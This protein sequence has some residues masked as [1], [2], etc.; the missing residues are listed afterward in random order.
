M[1]VFLS[2]CIAIILIKLNTGFAYR[3]TILH[4]NDLHA[5]FEETNAY[6]GLCF[7][8]DRKAGKCYGGVARR[9]AAI[10]QI[11]G[12]EPNVILLDAGDVLTGTLWYNVYRG[13]ASWKFMNELRYDVMTLGNHDFDD[14]PAITA[15]FLRNVN[16][17]VVIPTLTQVRN[18]YGPGKIHFSLKARVSSPGPGPNIRFLPEIQSVRTATDELRQKGINKIIAL[19]HS[20]IWVDEEIA[21]QVSG[22]DVVV[23]GHSNTFLY[24]GTPIKELTPKGPYPMVVKS[25]EGNKVPVVQAYAYGVYL[26]RL[27][28]EFDSQGKVTKWSGQPILLDNSVAKDTSAQRQVTVMKGEVDK[29]SQ[30]K[31]GRSLVYLNA[32]QVHCRLNECNLG[33]LVTDAMVFHYA[34]QTAQSV[35]WTKASIALQSSG[36]IMASIGVSPEEFITYGHM[37]NSLPYG[38][39]IDLVE[40]RG[41]DLKNVLEHSVSAYDTKNPRGSFL[42]V[43]GLRV[44][45]NINKPSG[46]RVT[47]V[48]TLCTQCREPIYQPLNNTAVYNVILPSY[49][50]NGG[51]GYT[52]IKDKRLSYKAG[53]TKDYDVVAEYIKTHS[54][55]VIGRQGR[56]EFVDGGRVDSKGSLA[57]TGMLGI[58]MIIMHLLLIHV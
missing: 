13:N 31:L 23:G 16:F 58:V 54:P 21:K 30:M 40:M 47:S 29:V 1:K 22:V 19:G 57:S 42:Q 43:S 46:Q 52:I 32:D 38:N 35:Q 37:F 45:Y 5:R 11:R 7:A 3:L 51:G 33:N 17:S 50:A 44:Q 36:S 18:A 56:I 20:G 53:T 49:I 6:G 12:G 41:V 27:D 25:N 4:T 14:G 10:K 28:V 48:Q 34:N 39:T 26:G 2:L 9:A 24:S 8:K 55:V 15:R